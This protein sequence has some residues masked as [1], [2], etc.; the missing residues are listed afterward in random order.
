MFRNYVGG[1][2]STFLSGTSAG[3]AACAGAVPS[4]GPD[5][6]VGG[7]GHWLVQTV[8]RL[9]EVVSRLQLLD[10]IRRE[11]RMLATLDDRML[12]DLGID[13]ATA[14]HESSR[15]WWDV[16]ANRL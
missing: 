5:K 4:G 14:D 2:S 10:D 8:R 15:R 12:R 6:R 3:A 1:F 16:P 9:V 13:Q 7:A 11:R